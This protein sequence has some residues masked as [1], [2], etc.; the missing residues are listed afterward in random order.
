MRIYKYRHLHYVHVFL[1]SYCIILILL[2]NLSTIFPSFSTPTLPAHQR[3]IQV[4]NP[5]GSRCSFAAARRRNLRGSPTAEAEGVWEGLELGRTEGSAAWQEGDGEG[6]GEGEGGA[7]NARRRLAANDDPTGQPSSQPS[8]YPTEQPS[9][10]PSGNPSSY[11][12]GQPSTQPSGKPSTQ[13]TSG[14]TIDRYIRLY[15]LY[16]GVSVHTCCSPVSLV[17]F[18]YSLC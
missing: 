8:T 2:A 12:S 17:G 11:P 16:T 6:E 18:I 14:N 5:D 7:E 4:C 15:I 1:L 9:G 3:P 10:Q 13:P